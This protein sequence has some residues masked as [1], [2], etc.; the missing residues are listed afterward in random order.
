MT[1]KEHADALLVLARGSGPGTPMTVLDGANP[2]N[3][4]PPYVLVY[5]ADSDPEE[6]ESRPLSGLPQRYVLRG[7]FHLVGGSGAATRALGDKLRSRL[8]N[9]TPTIAGRQCLP[10]RRE[11]GVPPERD[12]STGTL[13]MDRVDVYRL[14]SEPA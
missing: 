4:A 10:I 12:E 5:F 2:D 9:V 7:I 6:P 14:E 8:L 1:V 13:V 11:D 3:V